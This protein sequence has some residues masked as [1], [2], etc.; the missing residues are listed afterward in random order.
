MVNKANCRVTPHGKICGA[1]HGAG[2]KKAGVV[3]LHKGEIVLPKSKVKA[4]L[5][6]KSAD[7]CKG[8]MTGKSRSK[9]K[10]KKK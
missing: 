5:S 6:A 3:R 10:C 2:I 1:A 7:C 9:C 4:M 8:I